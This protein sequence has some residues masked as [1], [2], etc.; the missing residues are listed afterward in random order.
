MKPTVVTFDQPAS[1]A[2]E[3]PKTSPNKPA[4]TSA[5]PGRSSLGRV[6]VVSAGRKRTVPS[7]AVATK[8]TLT[9]MHQRQF[10]Y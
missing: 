4:E 2:C 5:M 3:K 1:D 9:N 8:P 7:S 10:R 6:G